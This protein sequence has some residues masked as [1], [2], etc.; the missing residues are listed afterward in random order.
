MI[1]RFGIS[2]K[3]SNSIRSLLVLTTI[4]GI[5][6]NNKGE[7]DLAIRD[8]TKAI[9]LDPKFAY[10]YNNRGNSYYNKERI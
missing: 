2:P 4:G 8:Y 3:P 9:E 7:Y 1:Q 10:A 5:S 6:Y